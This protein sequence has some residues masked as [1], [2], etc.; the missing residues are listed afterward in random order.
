M[1]AALNKMY[2]RPCID[3]TYSLEAIADAFQFE[4]SGHYFGRICMTI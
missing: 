3:T 2:F 4:E 1:V